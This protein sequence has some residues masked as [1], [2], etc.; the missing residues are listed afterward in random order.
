MLINIG[1]KYSELVFTIRK[2][3]KNKTTNLVE[4]ILQIIR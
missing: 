1:P 4:A 2:D 3:W